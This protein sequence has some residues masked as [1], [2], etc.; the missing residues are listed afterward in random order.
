MKIRS[1]FFQFCQNIVLLLC[2]SNV[3]IM[4]IP[5]S[6]V[7]CTGEYYF[8]FTSYFFGQTYDY[9]LLWTA[10]GLAI[11]SAVTAFCTIKKQKN[12]WLFLPI[13]NFLMILCEINSSNFYYSARHP[14][15]PLFL[16]YIPPTISAVLII[17]SLTMF[18]WTF[19]RN[20]KYPP[21]E[22]T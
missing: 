3:I 21:A 17:F 16:P 5:G 15:A 9:P 4:A 12:M 2:I 19:S 22:K 8:S 20:L 14:N 1:L 13:L 7:W 11:L 18:F 6:V 10:F